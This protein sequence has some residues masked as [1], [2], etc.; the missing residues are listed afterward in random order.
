MRK[1]PTCML[2]SAAISTLLLLTLAASSATAIEV[3]ALAV[4]S[5]TGGETADIDSATGIPPITANATHSSANGQADAT[6]TLNG[7]TSSL[8]VSVQANAPGFI[9]QLAAA[10]FTESFTFTEADDVSFTFDIDGTVTGTDTDAVGLVLGASVDIDATDDLSTLP[11]FVD[12]A[13][14]STGITSLTVGPIA[15]EA[16]VARE[17]SF[18]LVA[19]GLLAAGGDYDADFLNTATLTGVSNSNLAG[20]GSGNTYG[21]AFAVPEPSTF[22]LT[23]LGLLSLGLVG[24]RRRRS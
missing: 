16:N 3:A 12:S 2:A 19:T 7:A 22:A 18:V 13:A 1:L 10:A 6:A 21:A 20:T 23:A 5:E 11:I 9:L 17:V 15:F 4:S 24:W 14:V 8:G